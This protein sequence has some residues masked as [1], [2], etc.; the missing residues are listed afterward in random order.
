MLACLALNQKKD[1][2]HCKGE[3]FFFSFLLWAV[4]MQLEQPLPSLCCRINC[5]IALWGVPFYILFPNHC[6]R[7][8]W[9][10]CALEPFLQKQGN[11]SFSWASTP[12]PPSSCWVGM[13]TEHS[14]EPHPRPVSSVLLGHSPGQLLFPLRWWAQPMGNWTQMTQLPATPMP[15]SLP[16]LKL[17]WQMTQSEYPPPQGAG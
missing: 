16:L 9:E 8:G 7:G 12:R 17:R 4:S 1:R 15:P 14:L 3:T 10:C 5:R 2:Q 13:G 11:L 6:W